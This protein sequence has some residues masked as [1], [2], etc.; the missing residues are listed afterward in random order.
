MASFNKITPIPIAISPR[1]TMN[2]R[3]G[4]VYIRRPAVNDSTKS[5]SSNATILAMNAVF[6]DQTCVVLAST[7]M[8]GK[9][10]GTKSPELVNEIFAKSRLVRLL[11]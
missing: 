5:E 8:V 7:K 1:L 6:K 9:I 4:L 2:N 3:T 11:P 10:A